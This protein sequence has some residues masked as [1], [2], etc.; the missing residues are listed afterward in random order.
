MARHPAVM[1]CRLT[2]LRNEMRG[3]VNLATNLLEDTHHLQIPVVAPLLWV[4]IRTTLE[5]M[6]STSGPVMDSLTTRVRE[7][8]M[9]RGRHVECQICLN[10]LPVIALDPCHH[11]VCPS[12]NRRI[13]RCPFCR[14]LITG[15]IRLFFDQ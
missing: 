14:Q 9:E 7:P 3:L 2:D 4:E 1:V 12:C 15:R 8:D 11:T 10:G 5:N 13:T 6:L